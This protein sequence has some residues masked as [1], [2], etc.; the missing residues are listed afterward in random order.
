MIFYLDFKKNVIDQC[1]YLKISWSKFIFLLLCADDILLASNNESLLHEIKKFLSKHF[2]MK[3]LEVAYFVIGIQ[4]RHDR[5][6]GR[7]A[8]HREH[9]SREYS[10]DLACRIMYLA[11]CLL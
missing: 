8:Y 1:I 5:S 11:M 10:Q 9:M 2:R 4:I 6:C 3:D 7:V